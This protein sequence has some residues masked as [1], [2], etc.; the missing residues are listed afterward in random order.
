MDNNIEFVIIVS[1]IV[2]IINLVKKAKHENSKN[3]NNKSVTL[4]YVGNASL[5]FKKA[6]ITL[7][8]GINYNCNVN[9]RSFKVSNY[10]SPKD[11]TPLAIK[12]KVVYYHKDS[13]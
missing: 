1:K 7:F 3:K 5:V 4:P 2:L 13:W 6:F 11:L 10:L 12:A 8:K 9:L